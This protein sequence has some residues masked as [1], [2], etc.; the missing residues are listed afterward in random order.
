MNCQFSFGPNRSY[1]C[2]AGTIYAWSQNSLPPVLARLLGDP[3]HPQAIAIPYDVAFPMQPGTY[4]LCWKTRNGEDCHEAGCLGPSYARLAHF[5]KNSATQGAYTMR[6]VFGHNGSFFSSSPS[7]YCWQNLPPALE[8]NI[9]ACMM[10]RR[11][12][13]VALGVHGSYI[14]LYSD[15]TITFDLRGL[16]P[17]VEGMIRN[18]QEAA[19]RRGVMYIALNPFISGEFYAV[20]GD[21]SASWNFPTAWSADV[22]AISRAIKP[23]PLAPDEPKILPTVPPAEISMPEAVSSGGTGPTPAP[24]PMPT[25][26]APP[27]QAA[28]VQAMA[29]GGSGSS[30]ASAVQAQPSAA[31]VQA[32][33]ME[34]TSIDSTIT[35]IPSAVQPSSSAVQ[36]QVQIPPLQPIATGGSVSS[37]TSAFQAPTPIV[38]HQI[39]PLQPTATGGTVSSAASAFQPPPIQV[40]VQAASAQPTSI[41]ESLS[42][43][44]SVSQTLDAASSEMS[45]PPPVYAPIPT[46]APAS[47]GYASHVAAATA[48][49]QSYAKPPQHQARPQFTQRPPSLVAQ[50]AAAP[51]K[52]GWKKGLS[53]GFKAAGGINKLV[54]AFGGPGLNQ[55]QFQSPIQI[56]QQQNTSPFNLE[57]VGKIMSDVLSSGDQQQAQQQQQQENQNAFAA[58]VEGIQ[59]AAAVVGMAGIGGGVDQVTEQA[60][61]TIMLDALS[62]GNQAQQ[63]QQQENQNAFAAYVEG[64]QTAAAVAG[65]AGVVVLIR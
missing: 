58:Y 51:S 26:Q 62:S 43:I 24:I 37:V 52:L 28:P 3:A 38:Q 40:Q 15:G 7:G 63:Q 30:I 13:C 22:A 39:P 16:Y 42:S 31:Q 60:I 50:P 10:V 6:T 47:I 12:V 14:A 48:Q 61:G 21:G 32:A 1:F 64:I 2:S 19:R 17:M 41:G 53:L 44:A 33:P 55:N 20:Y 46:P 59:T 54:N 56:P 18:T 9:H 8:D 23:M 57:G 27:A 35:S 5:I 34:P 36:V 45:P 29:T 11:P 49:P 25:A 4:A 65:M